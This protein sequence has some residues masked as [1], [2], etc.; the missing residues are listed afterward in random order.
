MSR[1]F[2]CPAC[3]A[4][5]EV[6]N[7]FSRSVICAYCNQGAFITPGGLDPAGRGVQL[8]GT[9]S[10]L[11]IGARGRLEGEP[12]HVLGRLRYGYAGGYWDEWFVSLE[13]GARQLW[14]QEDDGVLT[15]FEKVAKSQP[16]RRTQE[17]RIRVPGGRAR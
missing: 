5:L 3:G 15:A 2:S 10:M 4:P 1:S 13:A 14:L 7:R 6:E 12:C 17:Q 8:V 9:P 16:T 11:R